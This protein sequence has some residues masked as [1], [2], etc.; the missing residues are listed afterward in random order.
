MKNIT[1]EIDTTNDP[2]PGWWWQQTAYNNYRLIGPN[3]GDCFNFLTYASLE[4]YCQQHHINP[5]QA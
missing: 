1:Q 5:K 2:S 3:H 4:R